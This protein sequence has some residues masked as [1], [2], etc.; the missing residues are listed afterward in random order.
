VGGQLV[1]VGPI[2]VVVIAFPGN[3]FNGRIL[4][5]LKSLRDAGTISIVDGLMVSKDA[6]G[7]VTFVEIDEEG[8]DGAV[9]ELAALC[10][11]FDEMI[12]DE[13]VQDLAADLD[14]DSSPAILVF[15]HTWVRPLRDA[16]VESGG[17]LAANFRVPPEAVAEVLAALETAS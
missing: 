2:E 17:V 10:D 4:P 16:I 7:E 12:T 9:A 11:R 15:E 3:R 6:Q 5:A 1:T 8:T 13:D 14:P